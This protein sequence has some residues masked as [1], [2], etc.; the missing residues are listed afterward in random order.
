MILA[1]LFSKYSTEIKA[2]KA[3]KAFRDEQGVICKKCKK[4][5]T[6]LEKR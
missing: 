1:E 3:F 5:N 6:L 2:K 4:H